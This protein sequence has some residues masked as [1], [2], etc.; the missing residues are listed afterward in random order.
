MWPRTGRRP[1]HGIGDRTRQRPRLPSTK[2]IFHRGIPAGRRCSRRRSSPPCWSRRWCS[3]IGAR[4]WVPALQGLT[5][6]AAA[7]ERPPDDDHYLAN[8]VGG[9]V[10]HHVLWFGIDAEVV[11]RLKAARGALRRQLAAD[12][13][14]APGVAAALLRRPGRALLRHGLRLPGSRPLSA[15]DDPPLRPAATAGGGQRRRLLRRRAQPVGRARQ[16]RH[17][18]CRAQAAAGGRSRARG[19]TRR[20][21]AGAELVPP[22]RPARPGPAPPLHRLPVPQRRHVG[23]LAV[24]RRH[25]RVRRSGVQPARSSAAEKSRR[26]RRSKPSST[27]VAPPWS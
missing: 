8:D 5:Q 11:R 7:A 21:P 19:P 14:A 10:D 4:L 26:R 27:A 15:G 18:V 3:T 1:R 16:P 20:S 13:R 6:E 17:A 2:W 9:Q 22:V 23:D 24:G 12:V 25:R